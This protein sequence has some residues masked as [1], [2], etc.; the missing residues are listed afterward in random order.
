MN[1]MINNKEQLPAITDE[2]LAE[3]LLPTEKLIE[4]ALKDFDE[5]LMIDIIKDKRAEEQV[6]FLCPNGVMPIEEFRR[7]GHEMIDELYAEI[8]KEE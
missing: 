6:Q 3:M 4:I 8:E 2:E 1:Q 5:Q 7:F